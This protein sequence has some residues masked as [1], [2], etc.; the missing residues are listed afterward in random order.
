M[1]E[2]LQTL[3]DRVAIRELIDTYARGADRRDAALEASAFAAD[4]EVEVYEGGPDGH[5]PIQRVRGRD[6]LVRTFGELIE[7]Y[8][9]TT[10]L[11]GQSSVR[12]RTADE[13]EGETY[14]VALHLLQDGDER[15]LLTMSIRYLDRFVKENGRWAIASRR[16]VFDWTDRRPS[17]P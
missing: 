15:F 14:C 10:Y 5:E 13:A 17:E 8:E 9:A 3:I 2:T 11:N 16:L 7:R 1:E 6:E 4:G 12:F